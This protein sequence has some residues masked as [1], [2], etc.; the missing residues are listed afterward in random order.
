ME[1]KPNRQTVLEYTMRLIFQ[2]R[3]AVDTANRQIARDQHE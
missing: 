2:T 1:K 3:Q